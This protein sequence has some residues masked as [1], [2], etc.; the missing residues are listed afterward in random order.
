MGPHSAT[1]SRA[2]VSDHPSLNAA[3]TSFSQ[4]ASEKWTPLDWLKCA[5]LAGLGAILLIGRYD[6]RGQ[7]QLSAIGFTLTEFIFL[8]LL[9]GTCALGQALRWRRSIGFW[10]GLTA[11]TVLLNLPFRWLGLDRAY[12]YKSHPYYYARQ[13]RFVPEWLCRGGTWGAAD[14]FFALLLVGAVALACW[15]LCR[16]P[17][18]R[19][20]LYSALFALVVAQLWLHQSDRSPYSYVP[21]FEQ[22]PSEDHAYTFSLLPGDRGLVNAD[23]LYF[24]RL[25]DLFLSVNGN[26][27]TLMARRAF[28]FYLSGPLTY[29]IGPYYSFNIINLLAWFAA[30]VA[31][32]ALVGA[33]AGPVAARYAAVLLACGSGFIMFAA[34]P[35]SYLAGYS[36]IVLMLFGCCKLFAAPNGNSAAGVLALGAI[37]GIGLLTTDLFVW[38]PTVVLLAAAARYPLRRILLACLIGLGTYLGYIWLLFSAFRLPHD[39]LNDRQMFD[40][41]RGACQLL[42]HPASAALYL[43]LADGFGTYL[44]QLL[45]AFLYVPV[46]LAIAG[47]F[48]PGNFAGAR[49]FALICLLPTLG[50]HLVMHA[51]GIWLSRLSR[52][53][54][55]AYPAIYCLAG[56][57]LAW[58]EGMFRARSRPVQ[59]I[60]FAGLLVLACLVVANADAFG[61]MPHLYY[62]FYYSFGGAFS[63]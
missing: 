6:W 45:L 35:M 31:L 5:A 61:G 53:D 32:D 23:A 4:T 37:L 54:Y 15:S 29:F 9:I 57:F 46:L 2:F 1:L 21:H 19:R 56:C 40:A 26:V 38:L 49:R 18:G 44:Q 7:A 25:E 34:Q 11:A 39:D 27:P 43:N 10:S 36:A 16:K 41:I 13:A 55:A 62:Y 60:C 58:C 28:I 24:T 14:W 50:T 30:V 48:A 63:G 51:G 33:I 22:P 12:Y 42:R 52:F 17:A 20:P 47:V 8:I 59:G 3:M